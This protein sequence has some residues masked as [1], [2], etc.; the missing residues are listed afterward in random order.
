ML[1][2]GTPILPLDILQ[3]ADRAGVREVNSRLWLREA[4]RTSA[5]QRMVPKHAN[6]QPLGTHLVLGFAVQALQNNNQHGAL[7]STKEREDTV[8]Q[9]VLIEAHLRM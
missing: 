5:A 7:H 4:Q 2:M 1:S 3:R 6:Q 9:S 8:W